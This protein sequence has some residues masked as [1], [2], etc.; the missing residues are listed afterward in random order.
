MKLTVNM[1]NT[2][3]DVI[4][5]KGVVTRLKDYINVDK[6]TII[7]TDD[8]VPS[9]YLNLVKNQLVNSFLYV[10]NQGEHHKNLETYQQILEYMLE[11]EF[12]RDSQLIALG[13]GVV[14]DLAG[15]VASSYKRGITFINI[16]TSLLAMVDSSIG[17]KV[18]VNLLS[19][20]NA[21]GAFY[22]PSIVLIDVNVLKTLPKRHFYNGLVEALKM[23]L[24]L[25][26]KLYQIFIDGNYE[27]KVEE[28]IYYSLKAKIQIVQ[29]DPIEQGSR[30]VL[31]FGHT[32]GHAIESK[33]LDK[34][35]HGEAVGIG[36]TFAILNKK[37]HEEVLHILEKMN[38]RV[39][40]SSSEIDDILHYIKNDK[41][42]KENKIDF[43][44]LND[45]TDYEIRKVSFDEIEEILKGVLK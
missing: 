27:E 39:N 40:L 20:K 9:I 4:L 29:L 14:G 37:L 24:T 19:Y 5:D 34:I 36:M 1:T 42:K 8:K 23:G 26:S 22:Q 12:D 28:V 21:V 16:P 35:Y 25:D 30:K 15:F 41:K 44:F 10:F 13:G 32:V 18:G 33:Y 3:Y 17:G 11:N 45:I 6:K 38:I 7:V 2:S 43:V 31:N